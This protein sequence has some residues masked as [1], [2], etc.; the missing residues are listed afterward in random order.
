MVQLL[1][2]F[3]PRLQPV[4]HSWEV[5]YTLDCLSSLGEQSLPRKDLTRVSGQYAMSGLA[6]SETPGPRAEYTD[7]MKKCEDGLGCPD[8]RN[9]G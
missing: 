4:P 7:A 6:N 3:L 5:I 8:L 2:K 1:K 9:P